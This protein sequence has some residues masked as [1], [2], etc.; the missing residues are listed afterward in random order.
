MKFKNP[1]K[2]KEIQPT[3]METGVNY[4]VEGRK[5]LFDLNGLDFTFE[6]FY[7]RLT[8]ENFTI[9]VKD[10]VPLNLV[11]VEGAARVEEGLEIEYKDL[12]DVDSVNFTL[13]LKKDFFGALKDRMTGIPVGE[14][15]E[16]EMDGEKPLKKF[17]NYTMV[18]WGTHT[19]LEEYRE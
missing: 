13:E 11:N 15:F 8:E 14:L 7:F 10:E 17:T 12:Q 5:V 18:R 1:F 16:L 6:G 9:D 2:K 19:V 3:L 4:H